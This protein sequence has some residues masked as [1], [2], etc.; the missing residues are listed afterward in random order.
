MNPG[1]TPAQ[2]RAEFDKV[3]LAYY[4]NVLYDVVMAVRGAP[5][6]GPTYRDIEK[7]LNNAYPTDTIVN[8]LRHAEQ[9]NRIIGKFGHYNHNGQGGAKKW[10]I[11]DNSNYPKLIKTDVPK[12][13]YD[14]LTLYSEHQA[15]IN[16]WLIK[17]AITIYN[18]DTMRIWHICQDKPDALRVYRK[19]YT[20]K[21]SWLSS[22]EKADL[23]NDGIP[24]V[25]CISNHGEKYSPKPVEYDAWRGIF[26]WKLEDF[27]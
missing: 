23:I 15:D 24:P 7:Q 9:Q 21:Y 27:Y 8:F 12:Y 14:W 6:W 1:I 13:P 25:Y 26:V 11:Y 4:D 17:N 5:Q 16:Q 2:P 22:K 18:K 19:L 10:F 20:N 3:W